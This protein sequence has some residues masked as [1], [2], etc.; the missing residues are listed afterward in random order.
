MDVPWSSHRSYMV[1][2]LAQYGDPYL[3]ALDAFAWTR[4]RAIQIDVYF[5]LLY[6]IESHEIPMCTAS[7]CFCEESHIISLVSTFNNNM[8]R[9]VLHD[10]ISKSAI[11]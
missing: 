4:G 6:F 5:T 1:G 8:M 2:G 11:G 7:I 10:K 9:G 3:S